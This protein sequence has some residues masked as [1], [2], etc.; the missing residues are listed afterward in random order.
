MPSGQGVKLARGR[1]L[2]R[3]SLGA[4]RARPTRC[5]QRYRRVCFSAREPGYSF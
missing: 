2:P 1:K 5:P 4:L 3:A